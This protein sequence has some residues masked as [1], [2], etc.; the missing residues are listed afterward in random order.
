MEVA[1]QP[2][3][4]PPRSS[5]CASMSEWSCSSD[6]PLRDLRAA[7]PCPCPFLCS[8]QIQNCAQPSRSKSESLRRWCGH[9]RCRLRC[10]PQREKKRCVHRSRPPRRCRSGQVPFQ[11]DN[12]NHKYRSKNI[13]LSILGN[14]RPW[15]L[16]V[17]RR[18]E[19]GRTKSCVGDW[20]KQA[21]VAGAGRD[22][23]AVVLRPT[24]HEAR[25]AHS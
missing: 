21:P 3:S 10:R 1:S 6:A 7:A 18:A 11:A 20:K 15:A 22:W 19:V 16:G 14:K 4:V 17:R 12:R 5:S 25:S 2:P 23:S 13:Y 24:R 8:W 9:C